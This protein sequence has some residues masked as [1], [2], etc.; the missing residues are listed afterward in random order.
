MNQK[1]YVS[2]CDDDRVALL[3]WGWRLSCSRVFLLVLQHVICAYAELLTAACGC[4]NDKE[5]QS[6]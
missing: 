1:A 5:I 4:H 2:D 3:F 6:H